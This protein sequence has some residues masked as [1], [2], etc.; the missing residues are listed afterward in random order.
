[1]TLKQNTL[2]NEIKSILGIYG[3]NELISLIEDTYELFELYNIDEQDDWI[4]EE[5]GEEKTRDIRLIRTAYLL[6]R[7]AEH[8]GEFLKKIVKHAPKFYIKAESLAKQEKKVSGEGKT[9]C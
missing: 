1:M 2:E 5:V 7:L 8:H 9:L 3:A 6:S 4:R